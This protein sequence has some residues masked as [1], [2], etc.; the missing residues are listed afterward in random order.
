M[1]T[2][3]LSA[4]LRARLHQE[5]PHLEHHAVEAERI[6]DVAV[7]DAAAL[8]AVDGG[9]AGVADVLRIK[10]AM[11]QTLSAS[12]SSSHALAATLWT[13]V[14]H[15]DPEAVLDGRLKAAMVTLLARGHDLDAGP[16]ASTIAE[17]LDV[18]GDLASA[19]AAELQ[20]Q[21]QAD[22]ALLPSLKSAAADAGDDTV[23]VAGLSPVK[24]AT[25]VTVQR[26]SKSKTSGGSDG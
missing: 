14:R 7:V 16:L 6:D 25:V 5:A 11:P 21:L 4:A 26:P 23:G 1:P 24:R 10:A 18:D 15:D 9:R 17:H 20:Q 8:P 2:I 12:S 22:P 13:Q 3:P 19:I